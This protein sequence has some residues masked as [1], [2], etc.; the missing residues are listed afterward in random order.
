MR[1]VF[2]GTAPV[3]LEVTGTGFEASTNVV[4]LGPARI[5]EVKSRTDG[6]LIE[7]EVPDRIPSGGGAAPVLWTSGRYPLTITTS[8]GTSNAVMIDV[9]EM[10]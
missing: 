8:R 1:V 9:Q 3:M 5:T 4:T 10:R 6:S 7:F 2:T